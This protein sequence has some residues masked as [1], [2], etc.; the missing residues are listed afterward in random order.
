MIVVFASC[1]SATISED[2]TDKEVLVYYAKQ[3]CFGK[4]PVF[5]LWVYEDGSFLYDGV[6][7]TTKKG[8]WEGR[9]TVERLSELKK[10]LSDKELPVITLKKIRDKP[11]TKLHYNG[12]QY[13]YHASRINNDLRV[14][15]SEMNALLT[16]IL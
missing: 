16:A 9:L 14:L 4:C 12:R 2:N 13:S 5:D 8:K 6:K 10:I 1:K 3:T 15:E 11:I 7:N